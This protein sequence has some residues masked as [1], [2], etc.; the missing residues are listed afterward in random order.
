VAEFEELRINATLAEDIS[1]KLKQSNV[2]LTTLGRDMTKHFTDSFKAIGGSLTGLGKEVANLTTQFGIFGGLPIFRLGLVGGGFAGIALAIKQTNDMLAE[3][4]RG[5]LRLRDMSRSVGLLPDQF[6]NISKQLKLVGY[7]SDEAEREIVS[8]FHKINEAGREGTSEF[9]HI[10]KTSA[11]PERAMAL[12]REMQNSIRNGAPGQAIAIA[13]HE[14]RAI[15]ER[16]LHGRG[17][18]QEARRQAEAW[19]DS[20]GLSMRALGITDISDFIGDPQKWQRRIEAA[21]RFNRE[22]TLFE[23]T[24]NEI[25][26][27]IK[28]ALLPAFQDLNSALGEGG[29]HAVLATIETDAQDFRKII[30]LLEGDWNKLGSLLPPGPLRRQL[31]GL[32]SAAGEVQGPPDPFGNKPISPIRPGPST[33]VDPLSGADLSGV[34]EGV[35][36]NINE[37][38][39]LLDELKRL[40]SILLEAE[41]V[42]NAS[43]FHNSPMGGAEGESNPIQL[44]PNEPQPG[45]GAEAE[46]RSGMDVSGDLSSHKLGLPG[47]GKY[48][49]PLPS[50]PFS[51]TP[52]TQIP[53]TPRSAQSSGLG[54][55]SVYGN[56]PDLGFIDKEDKGVQGTREE[57]QGIALGPTATRGQYHY[58]RDPFTGLTHVVKQ[59][60]TG[61][62]YRTQK[63]LD[64]HASQWN[65]M[66]Y[67]AAQANALSGKGLWG[68][69][70]TGF[71]KDKFLSS[72]SLSTDTGKAGSA[73]EGENTWLRNLAP[74]DTERAKEVKS[75]KPD[76]PL[77]SPNFGQIA[78][79]SDPVT[80]LGFS[81]AHGRIM[82]YDDPNITN[83]RAKSFIEREGSNTY[84]FSYSSVAQPEIYYKPGTTQ[85]TTTI[86][87]E[88][89]H[90]GRAAVVA[91][92]PFAATAE[93]NVFKRY[94]AKVNPDLPGRPGEVR[95][96]YDAEE[97]E[98]RHVDYSENERLFKAGVI[99][100][101]EFEATK[102]ETAAALRGSTR[103]EESEADRHQIAR[104]NF[105]AKLLQ[106]RVWSKTS[107][108]YD[109]ERRR[110]RTMLDRGLAG[111][112]SVD[113]SA[114]L[115][116]NVRGPAGV[117]V[118]A[119]G[120]GMFKGNTS[121]SQQV[122]M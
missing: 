116:V 99:D 68:V 43:K 108:D 85:D 17:G 80:K 25:S 31:M 76:L 111:E 91:A 51:A 63:L 88:A 12:V 114:D 84:G 49:R 1:E 75:N 53:G 64:I 70:P 19:L 23:K 29:F 16:E 107:K 112:H 59:S 6:A 33:T 52:L 44:P 50:L 96:E 30:A 34:N 2:Q 66:G 72:Q 48:N 95:T 82:T 77:M 57:D 97:R 18:M 110:D 37:G 54:F 26:A 46:A 78:E 120:E 94:A 42:A 87:H 38:K 118:K 92:A 55:A 20:V 122:A 32:P 62:G 65:R 3:F 45:G 83:P 104:E 121:V 71:E 106:S 47:G 58:L 67:T 93:P 13:A 11:T 24:L 41:A 90:I 117:D 61:P 9:L 4:S 74:Q 103:A 115:D 35:Q 8:F 73:D 60:D 119:N 105:A 102:R 21:E 113:A 5:M 7:S 36:I 109:A 89:G 79:A 81:R 69:Q 10:Y 40:N 22:Y 28:T 27:E 56:R 100:K 101:D 98:Q 86:A 15:W 14:A 39:N